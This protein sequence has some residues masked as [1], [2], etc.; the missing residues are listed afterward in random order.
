M[1]RCHFIKFCGIVSILFL[2]GC[3]RESK[4][5]DLPKLYPVRITVTQEEKPLENARIVL[6]PFSS[7][8]KWTSGGVT[9]DSGV[10]DIQTYGKYSGAPVGKYKVCVSKELIEEV[11]F[12]GPSENRPPAK[13]YSLV[14]KKYES[15]GTTPLEIDILEKSN[16]E[17]Y[18][19]GKAVK[20]LSTGP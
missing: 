2:M 13:S 10:V 1:R 17:S 3:N 20:I 5:T 6:V 18:D 16:A 14:E 9:N 15:A 11:P 4:P 7:P 12:D 8:S 19:L